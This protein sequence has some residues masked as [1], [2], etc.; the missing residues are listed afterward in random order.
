MTTTAP[1]PLTT[2]PALPDGGLS[3]T[4]PTLPGTTAPGTA[5]LPGSAASPSTPGTAP[6][7][8][9]G[10]DFPGASLSG[11]TAFPGTFL[12]DAPSQFDLIADRRGT[13]SLKWD[14]A[15]RRRR[16]QD[17]LPLWVDYEIGRASCRERV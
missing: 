1:A 15:A 3:N 14:F 16:P 4:S 11:A 2:A 5:T 6:A 17:A 13:G 9:G 8:L 7:A 10:A 12:P